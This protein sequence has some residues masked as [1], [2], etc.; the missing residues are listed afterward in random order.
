MHYLL[1]FTFLIYAIVFLICSLKPH[2]PSDLWEAFITVLQKLPEIAHVFAVG[3]RKQSES[4]SL[5]YFI[6]ISYQC[7]G[8]TYMLLTKMSFNQQ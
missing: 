6:Y 8:S 2:V 5:Y 1:T 7:V 3:I 4:T